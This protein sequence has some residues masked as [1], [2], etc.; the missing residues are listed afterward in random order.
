MIMR[1]IMCAHNRIIPLDYCH[2]LKCFINIFT[3][4][5]N[6]TGKRKKAKTAITN[7]R[8]RH[9]VTTV[10]STVLIVCAF[11]MSFYI[12]VLLVNICVCHL[13]TLSYLLTCSVS[14]NYLLWAHVTLRISYFVA[15][16]LLVYHR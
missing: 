6:K 3:F 14:D 12:V 13:Y 8:K 2:R 16:C 7:H 9:N 5:M 1:K 10:T 15:F 11:L 4:H